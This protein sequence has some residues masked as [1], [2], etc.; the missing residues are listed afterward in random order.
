[1]RKMFREASALS[2]LLLVVG[3]GQA[4]QPAMQLN[5][6]SCL[7]CHVSKSLHGPFQQPA[8]QPKQDAKSDP[9]SA[10]KNAKA[11]VVPAGKST[12]EEAIEEAL[13]NNLDIRVAES[14]LREA[15]EVLTQTKLLV[16][17]KVAQNYANRRATEETMN[18]LNRQRTR[19]KALWA[20]GGDRNIPLDEVRK[21]EARYLESKAKLAQV[22]AELPYLL[23]RSPIGMPKQAH[24]INLWLDPDVKASHEWAKLFKQDG[25]VFLDTTW[26]TAKQ[27]KPG[28]M[29]DRIRK[30][31][32]TDIAIEFNDVPGLDILRFLFEASDLP[33][34]FKFSTD[35]GTKLEAPLRMQIKGKIPLFAALQ[36]FQDT[37]GDPT[38]R[39]VVR[40][41]GILVTDAKVLPEGAVTLTDFAKATVGKTEAKTPAPSSIPVEPKKATEPKKN[42][43]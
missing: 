26:A 28:P 39:F 5:Q 13:K 19:D 30:A 34:Q 14:K 31:I 12:L 1:M 25:L 29:T 41:Y 22:D 15:Q 2:A 6:E 33:F 10:D 43:E 3:L 17:N 36:L 27:V 16:A 38:L 9:A 7:A 21:S 32:D 8:N 24:D 20:Q 4:Q 37:L 35:L 11:G 18:E 42:P 23:G 40:D